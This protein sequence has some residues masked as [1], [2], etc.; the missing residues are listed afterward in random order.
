MT[1]LE[2]HRASYPDMGYALSNGEYSLDILAAAVAIEPAHPEEGCLYSLNASV[3]RKQWR[4][5]DFLNT[6]IT[7]LQI[8][9]KTIATILK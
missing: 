7:P 8:L 1:S 5:E 9:G 3:P 6:V 2:Q 4:E